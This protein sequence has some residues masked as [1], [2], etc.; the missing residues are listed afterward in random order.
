[1][2][3]EE[4]PSWRGITVHC[5]LNRSACT[6]LLLI[7]LA[8]PLQ[9]QNKIEFFNGKEVAANEVLVK[10]RAVPVQAILQAEQAAEVDVAV[11]VGNIGVLRFHS[12]SKN[13][14]KLVAELSARPDVEYAEP[15]YIL[16]ADL[17]PNDPRFSEL[18]GLRNTGQPI[19][20]TPGTPGAD[21]SAVSAWDITTGSRANV[22][23]VVDTGIDYNHPDLAANVWS[24]PATFTVSIGGQA[25][26]CAAGTHGFNAITNTCDPLDNNSHGT[27]VSGIIGAVGNNGVGVVGVNWIASIMG[28]KFLDATGNGTTANAINA[29]EFTIQAKTAFAA[30]A[31]ANVRVLSNSWNGGNFSQAL[32][33]EI[34][35]ANAN[36]ML[37]VAAAGNNSSNNDVTPFYPSSYNTPN[38]VAVAATDNTDALASFSNFGATSVHLGAPGVSILSTV[39]AGGYDYRG[40]TSMATPH[41]AG[42][43]ALTRLMRTL[44]FDV[45]PTDPMV[46]AAVAVALMAVAVAASAVPSLRV[47]RIR[48]ASA[49]RY[50]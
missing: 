26:T 19:L 48:P 36:D 5:A 49:L 33:D 43:F 28:S 22:V 4:F 18:W 17:V 3:E 50:E 45:K 20:G 38:M 13:A 25:I 2:N 29:I 32:L 30:T 16:Y 37:F 34:N 44:L 41:V 14:A 15:N 10:F 8:F 35:R 12:R 21:I 42:A 24:A 31:G 9:G 1:M 6:W 11:E 7:V 23:G 47:T 39:T 46:F 40:G 27:H